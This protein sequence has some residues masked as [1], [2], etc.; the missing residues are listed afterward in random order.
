M[1]PITVAEKSWIME[2]DVVKSDIPLLMSKDMMK[3]IRMIIDLEDDTVLVKGK[4]SGVYFL[5]LEKNKGRMK[6]EP[7]GS[8]R[9][10]KPNVESKEKEESDKKIDEEEAQDE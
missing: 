8:N 3:K 7:E 5:P 9:Y 1:I 4:K 2:V 10:L 6:G